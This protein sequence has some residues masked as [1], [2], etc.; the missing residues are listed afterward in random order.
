MAPL[1]KIVMHPSVWNYEQVTGSKAC[2]S[3]IIP[4]KGDPQVRCMC[5]DEKSG[6]GGCT[7]ST[8]K[9]ILKPKIK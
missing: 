6:I 3:K 5:I 4:T 2:I 9:E 8:T 7:I 1:C